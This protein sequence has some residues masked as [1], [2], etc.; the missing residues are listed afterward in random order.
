MADDTT[1]SEHDAEQSGGQVSEVASMDP[2]AAD[3]PISDDQAVAGYPDSES[4]G[5]DEPDEAGPNAKPGGNR[6]E[7]TY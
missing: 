4:G 6:S 2:A 7:N 3:T 1:K 5:A